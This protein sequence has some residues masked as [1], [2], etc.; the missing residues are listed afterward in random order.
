M[1]WSSAVQDLLP[2]SFAFYNKQLEAIVQALVNREY[3][4]TRIY[5]HN[6]K[7]HNNV[8]Q[9]FDPCYLSFLMLTVR[10]DYLSKNIIEETTLHSKH[11]RRWLFV[12]KIFDPFGREVNYLRLSVTEHCNWA[13]SIAV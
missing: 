10:K 2:A 1:T 7:I 13:V 5:A 6:V 12:K 3:R 8:I 9:S 11:R 4:V